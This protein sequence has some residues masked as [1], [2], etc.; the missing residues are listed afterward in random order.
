[1]KNIFNEII[2]K[3]HSLLN[4][5]SDNNESNSFD[6]NNSNNSSNINT[7]NNTENMSELKNLKVYKNYIYFFTLF[8]ESSIVFK[9][10]FKFLNKKNNKSENIYLTF[11]KFIKEGLIY[12]LNCENK[13]ENFIFFDEYKLIINDLKEIYDLKNI[14][15]EIKLSTDE[16]DKTNEIFHLDIETIQKLVNEIVFQKDIRGKFKK[17]I[18]TLFISF[19]Q[20]GYFNNFP[21]INILSLYKCV[22]LNHDNDID[23]NNNLIKTLNDIQNYIISIILISCNIKKDDSFSD[24]NLI[25]MK[26]KK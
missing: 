21:L 12:K 10:Y 25:M 24:S 8:F 1:M 19:N 9:N 16:L 2:S 18:E 13:V 26:Y 23:I 5:N 6:G 7:I 20:S 3:Y 4:E 14:F 17:N 22:L 15:R 11:P